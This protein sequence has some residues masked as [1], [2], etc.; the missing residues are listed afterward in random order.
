MII[1]DFPHFSEHSTRATPIQTP[2]F[3][4]QSSM[5]IGPEVDSCEQVKEGQPLV[6]QRMENR[7]CNLPHLLFVYQADHTLVHQCSGLKVCMESKYT[8][9]VIL[10]AKCKPDET[11]YERTKVRKLDLSNLLVSG[12]PC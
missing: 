3:S 9:R 5:C 11:K 7:D 8:Q 1:F 4:Y 10:S 2:D 6:F 12:C